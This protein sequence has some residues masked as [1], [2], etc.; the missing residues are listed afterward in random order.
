[1][2]YAYASEA[3]PVRVGSSNLPVTTGM[4]SISEFK[5]FFTSGY[6]LFVGVSILV[7]IAADLAGEFIGHLGGNYECLPVFGCTTG[8]F[9]FDAFEHFL[10]GFVFVLILALVFKRYP[11]ISP[12]SGLDKKWKQALVLICVV[13]LI[14]VVWEFIE[15][16]HDVFRLVVLHE[17]LYNV[18]LHIDLLDQPSNLDTMGDL[19]FNVL[20]S[21]IA[22]F[23]AK[24]EDIRDVQRIS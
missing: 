22:A 23:F 12:L 15:C 6:G 10:S 5:R 2:V 24:Y 18:R 17:P 7:Y 9:G 20:G 11:N 8:F 3:Y 14:A 1:L 19:A 21:V 16:A 4:I 13:A